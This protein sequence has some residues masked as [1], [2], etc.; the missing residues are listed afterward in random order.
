MDNAN[1]DLCWRERRKQ[2]TMVT[3]QLFA[4][5]LERMEDETLDFKRE[6]YDL[7]VEFK[8]YAL[9]KDVI[10]MANTPRAEDSYIILGVKKHSDGKTDLIGLKSHVDEADLQSQFSERVHPVPRLRYEL[11]NYQGKDFGIIVIPPERVG[12]CAPLRDYG[13]S[14]RQRQIYFRRGSKNDLATPEDVRRICDWI[15]G[16]NER[17][18]ETAFEYPNWENFIDSVQGFSGLSKY[19]L[20]SNLPDSTSVDGLESLGAVDWSFAIDLDP[21]SDKSGPVEGISCLLGDETKRPLGRKGRP[22]YFE[23]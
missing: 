1:P 3:E 8:K 6:S 21:D 17:A 23:S 7:S 20:L 12:P 2:R 10:C 5:L 13:A 11:V 22:P 15:T 16:S 4:S 9:V 19:I 18:W 14:L